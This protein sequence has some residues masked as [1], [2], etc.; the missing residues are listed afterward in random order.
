MEKGGVP[1]VVTKNTAHITG[2]FS[3]TPANAGS[4]VSPDRPATQGTAAPTLPPNQGA[5]PD[6]RRTIAVPAPLHVRVSP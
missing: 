2:V 6:M 1:K 3:A 4:P 5:S